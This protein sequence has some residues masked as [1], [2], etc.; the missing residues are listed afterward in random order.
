MKELHVP[1]FQQRKHDDQSMLL[2]RRA[3]GL[4]K[5]WIYDNVMHHIE[6]TNVHS[7]WLKMESLFAQKT[8]IIRCT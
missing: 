5:Q 6:E 3:C 2:H 8:G 7:L 1:V 4:I